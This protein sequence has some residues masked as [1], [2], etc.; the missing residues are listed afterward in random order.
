[1]ADTD[2]VQVISEARVDARSLSEFVFKPAG[3]KVAR[4]LAP[5]IDTLQF[6]IDRFDALD[7]DFK[8]SVT[9]AMF[10]LNNSVAEAEGK[11]EYIGTTVQDAINNTATPNGVLADTF[12]TVTK[13][14]ANAI[15]RNQ[16][17]VNTDYINVKDY[18][19]KGDGIADDTQAFRNAILDAPMNA[20]IYMPRGV[21]K[22]TDELVWR[23]KLSLVG[24]G[25]GV[26]VIKMVGHYFSAINGAT[27]GADGSYFFEDCRFE[28]F[29]IDGSGLTYELAGVG[30]KGLFILFMIRPIFRNLYIHHT[31]GTGL[32]C[33]FLVD[34]VIDS[35]NVSYCGRNYGKEGS[36]VG[37]SGIGIGT[38][39][40]E[41]E[42][43]SITNCT[44]NFN[45][46]HGVF[47]EIQGTPGTSATPKGAKISNCYAEGNLVG[48]RNKS[49]GNT[50]FDSC[51]AYKNKSEGFSNTLVKN[52]VTRT[53]NCISEANIGHGFQGRSISALD[54]YSNCL[55][56]DNGDRG[57][58]FSTSSINED[59][60]GGNGVTLQT[61]V[62][63]NNAKHGFDITST[64]DRDQGYHTLIGCRSLKSG[65]NGLYSKYVKKFN[66]TNC[67]FDDN[68]D[69]GVHIDQPAPQSEIHL[70]DTFARG[71]GF[72]GLLV[73]NHR[74]AKIL[75][76]SR[77]VYSD[78][79]VNDIAGPRMGI[80]ISSTSKVMI[81]GAICRNLEVGG[82]Q[83]TGINIDDRGA[84]TASFDIIN[85]DVRDNTF[86]SISY[87]TS[88]TSVINIKNNKGFNDSRTV[89][90]ASINASPASI[91]PRQYPLKYFI[92]STNNDI[93]VKRNGL[94]L[95]K[96]SNNAS[97][98]VDAND[99]GYTIEYGSAITAYAQR[100]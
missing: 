16:H 53:S 35:C 40:K 52:A 18:G 4:R 86:S 88:S 25:I 22:I 82:K 28:D 89:N 71:N 30:G 77:G 10:N 41:V 43:I 70:V 31:I 66:I 73:S 12:L 5:T 65:L 78:N 74:D 49:S 2:I 48:F 76:I 54:T 95:I 69:H 64:N 94:V 57:Y 72:N 33:D 47:V 98:D 68:V 92:T 24:D 17:Q 7:G 23:T 55:S 19:A 87:P 39:W 38:G 81:D 20:T 6:Y 60:I 50:I 96:N 29:E 36:T 90:S 32:G 97:I 84:A 62:A 44:T 14:S 85:N 61:C 3:F 93:T 26:S 75:N 9:T 58:F 51:Y 13:V 45:G 91:A 83:S 8:S 67:F 63:F 27:R 100:Y 59:F 99:G 46:N 42:S 37:Q 11:V 80:S 56:I 79:G 15:P 34:A 21:Y 1:M